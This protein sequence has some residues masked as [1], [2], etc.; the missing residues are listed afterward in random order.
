[1]PLSTG[2]NKSLDEERDLTGKKDLLRELDLLKENN[3]LMRPPLPHIGLELYRASEDRL[4]H[5]K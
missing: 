3:V 1:M 5:T 2:S 4:Y